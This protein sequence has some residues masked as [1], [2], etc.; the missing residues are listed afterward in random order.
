MF[1]TIWQSSSSLDES[2]NRLLSEIKAA[3]E[4]CSPLMVACE[5]VNGCWGIW[6]EVNGVKLLV[7]PMDL[8]SSIYKDDR[9]YLFDTPKEEVGVES[10]AGRFY[11][12]IRLSNHVFEW[13]LSN[14]LLVQ[15]GRR[16]FT[17]EEY[18]SKIT[19]AITKLHQV[20]TEGCPVAYMPLDAEIEGVEMCLKQLK[21][22][23]TLPTHYTRM[24][25]DVEV[26]TFEFLPCDDD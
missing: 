2:N 22:S 16:T 24:T 21:I 20:W 5:E 7:N 12:E 23:A 18:L 6:L 13:Q 8:V 11:V 25:K 10:H 9:Y 17:F 3:E 1:E 19:Q 14:A 26:E 4:D 15:K